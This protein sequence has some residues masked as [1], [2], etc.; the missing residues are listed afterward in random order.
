VDPYPALDNDVHGIAGVPFFKNG[1][2]HFE[3]DFFEQ[4]GHLSQNIVRGL[5]K[6]AYGTQD[7]R[8]FCQ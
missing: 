2:T 4:G 5:G 1:I 3:N 7:V 6:E 8:F